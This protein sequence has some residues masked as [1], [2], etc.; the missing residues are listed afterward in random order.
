MNPAGFILTVVFVFATII[1][2]EQFGSEWANYHV[3]TFLGVAICLL[4]APSFYRS[5]RSR[6]STQIFLVLGFIVAMGVSEV[7]NGWFGG[8]IV[9][10][11]LLLP[12]AVGFFFI[13]A[14]VTT[15]RRLKILA[16]AIVVA[17]L[18]VVV[19]AL[20]DYYCGYGGDTFLAYETTI[21]HGAVVGYFARIRGA[22][23]LSDPNDLAQMLLIALPLTTIAWR[24]GQSVLNSV[25]VVAP[26]S[27]LLWGIFLTH[28][29]GALIGIAILT[30]VIMR[31]KRGTFSA[32]ILTACV[33]VCLFALNFTGGRGISAGAGADR[34]SLWASG[35]EMFKRSPIFGLGFGK[36]GDFE[37]L[38][39]HNSFVLCLAELGLVGCT[40]WVALLVTTIMGLNRIIKVR[41]G[42]ENEPASSGKMA[43]EKQPIL[44]HS[45]SFSFE[46]FPETSIATSPALS[47]QTVMGPRTLPQMPTQ[48]IMAIRLAMISFISTC[49]FLS[50]TYEPT[51]FLVVGV[52]TAAITLQRYGNSPSYVIRWISY[53]LGTEA[54]VICFI[55]LVVRLRF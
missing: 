20:S 54:V 6:P 31:Q 44:R 27:L 7:A 28:S 43:R 41:G 48:W 51:F 24:K 42:T 1:S 33:V 21:A 15:V 14:N 47:V 11:K 12:S 55:Y 53:T 52:A 26:A 36:F 22:G 19:E 25:T 30:M 2:P 8:V 18:V 10:W 17:C 34:L 3:L 32:T 29:R 4:S 45:P 39:A 38:T 40:F 49:W 46:N 35:L 23:F 9:S 16:A 37:D 5:L 13:V 50:R